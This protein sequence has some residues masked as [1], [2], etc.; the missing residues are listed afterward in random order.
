MPDTTTP[1]ESIDP[2]IIPAQ[3]L[4]GWPDFHPEAF[5]HRCGRRNIRAW[6]SPEWV[7]L[8][9]SFSGILC[10][11]CFADHDTAAIWCLT[12]HVEPGKEQVRRL[13][14]V[15]A[16]TTTLGDDSERVARIAIDYLSS[17]T[18]DEVDT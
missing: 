17:T 7:P 10:P 8:T 4:A 14:A 5:C 12:R 13:A 3:R 1:T 2:S 16:E 9:G 11:V 6:H 15:L 18:G